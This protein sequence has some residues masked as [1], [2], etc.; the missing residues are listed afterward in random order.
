MPETKPG[1]DDELLEALGNPAPD[2]VDLDDEGE[3]A[4]LLDADP[5]DVL[6]VDKLDEGVTGT[7]LAEG[8]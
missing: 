3:V 8:E 5:A 7:D 4:R 6:D 2:Q 1:D